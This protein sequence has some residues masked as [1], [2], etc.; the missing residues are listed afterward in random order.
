MPPVPE[1]LGVVGGHDQPGGR[2]TRRCPPA[3]RAPPRRSARHRGP[4]GRSRPPGRRRLLRSTPARMRDRPQPDA[5]ELLPDVEVAVGPCSRVAT[6]GGPDQ[7]GDLRS[8]GTATTSVPAHPP[9]GEGAAT[10]V[11]DGLLV[12]QEVADDRRREGQA[13][14]RGSSRT[15]ATRCP[16]GAR[17]AGHARRQAPPPAPPPR[18]SGSSSGRNG[19]A[20]GPPSSSTTPRPAASGAQGSRRPPTGWRAARGPAPRAATRRPPCRGGGGRG[21]SPSPGPAS[22][23]APPRSRRRRACRGWS[24]WA[25]RTGVTPRVRTSRWPSAARESSS[26]TSGR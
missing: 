9:G 19:C 14:G 2:S 6:A 5:G 17:R 15:P 20:A 7:V 12:D 4:A 22:P 13:P 10:R 21:R 16:A 24:S 18:T 26:A 25:A 11:A 1:Q 23:T 8:R 3:A